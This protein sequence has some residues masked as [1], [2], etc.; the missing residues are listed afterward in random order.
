MKV[1]SV[2]IV[3]QEMFQSTA[4]NPLTT[5]SNQFL[6]SPHNINYYNMLSNRQV[7]RIKKI[8]S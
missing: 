6:N 8:I 2:Q 7:M 3:L 5:R 4:F 1:Y